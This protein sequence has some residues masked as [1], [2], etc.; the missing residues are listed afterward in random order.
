MLI[1]KIDVYFMFSH[2][3]ELNVMFVLKVK[4]DHRSKFSNLNIWKE[5]V[6]CAMTICLS[7]RHDTRKFLAFTAIPLLAFHWVH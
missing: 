2:Y 1:L 3:P 4:N 5:Y 7:Y 6:Q